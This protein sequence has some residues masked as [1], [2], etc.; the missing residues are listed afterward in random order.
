MSLK[1]PIYLD[2]D[3]KLF[4]FGKNPYTVAHWYF[5]LEEELMKE[6]E[7]NGK[8]GA[9]FIHNKRQILQGMMEHN[10]FGL[11]MSETTSLYANVTPDDPHFMMDSCTGR[12]H[13]VL[14]VFCML[15]KD[16]TEIEIL[17]VAERMRKRGLGRHIVELFPSIQKAIY[18]HPESEQFWSKI[19]FES[20]DPQSLE[21]DWVPKTEKVLT[22]IV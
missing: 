13:Y 19:G 21:V 22:W 16:K 5:V 6:W 18:V 11:C 3:V 17:W 1:L 2:G 14:P 9:S 8:T 20:T 15:D 12:V 10:V 7:C 4:D